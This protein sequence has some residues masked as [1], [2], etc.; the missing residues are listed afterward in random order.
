MKRRRRQQT[1][2][3]S[4]TQTKFLSLFEYG[5]SSLITIITTTTLQLLLLLICCMKEM[6]TERIK[7]RR[8]KWNESLEIC[9]T[10][11]VTLFT[12]ASYGQRYQA[13]VGNIVAAFSTVV[14]CCWCS[15][16]IWA[17]CRSECKPS[18]KRTRI[19]NDCQCCR[20]EFNRKGWS[21]VFRTKS[22]V[23]GLWLW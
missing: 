13:R 7:E 10:S 20:L 3:H 14:H 18:D 8:Q 16:A 21:C 11:P 22:A 4:S 19:F 9:V 6:A 15:L 17:S 12:S 2:Q 23:G 1:G 5:R